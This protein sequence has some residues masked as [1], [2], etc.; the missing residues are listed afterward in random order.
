MRVQIKIFI[1]RITSKNLTS[2]FF[3]LYLLLTLLNELTF[4]IMTEKFLH[5]IINI[6]VG[7]SKVN[8][9]GLMMKT[10]YLVLCLKKS[11]IV[12][13]SVYS[14]HMRWQG[15]L[16]GSFCQEVNPIL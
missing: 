1:N 12:R 4:V 8:E 6:V 5:S 11:G 9:V 15:N 14:I 3:Y 13:R 10:T 7:I 2:N 16:E